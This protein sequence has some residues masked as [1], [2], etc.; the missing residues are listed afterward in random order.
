[1]FNNLIES[2]SHA[3]EF[4]RRGS[5]LLFT[6]ATYVVLFAVTGVI[7]IYAYDAHLESPEYRIRASLLLC[8][9]LRRRQRRKKFEIQFALRRTQTQLP[10]VQRARS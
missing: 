2:S 6:T 3:Q 1:M 7:S 10:V 5:F 4:K 9:C 8:R